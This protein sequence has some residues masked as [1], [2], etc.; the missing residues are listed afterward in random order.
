MSEGTRLRFAATTATLD[1]ALA[2]LD[3]LGA[4]GGGA[5]EPTLRR[6][7]LTAYRR[8]GAVR[9]EMPSGWRHPYDALRFGDAVWSAGRMRVPALPTH[10]PAARPGDEDAPALATENAGGIVHVGST[11]LEPEGATGDRR[12]TLR[13]LADAMRAE[14]EAVRALLGKLVPPRADRFVALAT[15]FQNCGAFINVPA[16]VAIEAPLQ[17][18]WLSRPG[19]TSAVFP[20]TV[21]RLGAG[22][23]ATIVERHVGSRENVTAGTVEI[24]LG[25]GARLDYVVVQQADDGARLAMRRAARVGA[26]AAIGWHV[27]ELGGALSRSIVESHL[28]GEGATSRASML[29]CPRGF[30]HLDLAVASLHRAAGTRADVATRLVLGEHARARLAGGPR[31]ARDVAARGI[32]AVVS[33]GTLLLSRHARLLTTPTLDAASHEARFR[34]ASAIGS[35]DPEALFYVASRGIAAGRAVAMLALAYLEPAIARFPSEALRDEVRS[36]LD[37]RLD[38]VPDTFAS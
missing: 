7:A 3:A 1:A 19:E 17:T 24:D 23:R 10:V 21:V 4:T 2:R 38:A 30:A 37:E 14:P 18:I 8:A 5:V 16:G 29:G 15:A 34:R 32:D 36:A 22:A 6:A 31:V 27:A 9:L 20:Q 12:V 11:Y 35:L 33:D 13:S 25:P 26:R 28:A